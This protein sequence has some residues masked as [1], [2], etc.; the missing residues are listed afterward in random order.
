MDGES[1]DTILSANPTV[2]LEFVVVSTA[3]EAGL[4][5]SAGGNVGELTRGFSLLDTVL[6]A[7]LSTSDGTC[8]DE[9]SSKKDVLVLSLG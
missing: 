8:R 2:L 7:E 5:K 1:Y 3:G 4:T 9:L 6:E